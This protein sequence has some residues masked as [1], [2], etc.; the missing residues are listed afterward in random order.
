MK[1]DAPREHGLRPI[2]HEPN[3]QSLTLAAAA[4]GVKLYNAAG[5]HEATITAVDLPN[6]R[7][8]VRYVSSGAIEPKQLSSVAHFRYTRR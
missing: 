4:V 7:I 1:G 3:L 6:D 8:R 5:V 2:V